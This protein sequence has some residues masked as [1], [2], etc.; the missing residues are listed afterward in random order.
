MLPSVRYMARSETL[1]KLSEIVPSEA[2]QEAIATMAFAG[3]VGFS[4]RRRHEEFS[5]NGIMSYLVQLICQCSCT[6]NKRMRA[7]LVPPLLLYHPCP[8]QLALLTV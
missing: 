2:A 7:I 4:P 6:W 8:S 1:T 3:W 5:F